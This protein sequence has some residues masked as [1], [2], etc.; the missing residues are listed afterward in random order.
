MEVSTFGETDVRFKRLITVTGIQMNDICPSELHESPKTVV[1]QI[2]DLKGQ[3]AVGSLQSL[4]EI[5]HVTRLSHKYMTPRF[6]LP[7]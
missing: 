7:H 3:S 2:S 1:L 6:R 4:H 5:Y